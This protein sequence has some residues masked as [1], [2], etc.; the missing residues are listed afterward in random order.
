MK[1]RISLLLFLISLFNSFLLYSQIT[2]TEI[3]KSE[4][5]IVLKPE[6]YDSLNNWQ[7]FERLGDY[8]QYIG[9]KIYLPPFENPVIGSNVKGDAIRDSNEGFANENRLNVTNE[10]GVYSKHCMLSSKRHLCNGIVNSKTGNKYYTILNVVYG[11]K[12]I[13]SL[14]KMNSE[15]RYSIKEFYLKTYEDVKMLFIIK[16]DSTGD[17]IYCNNTQRFILV[18]YFVKQK[19]LFQNNYFI[20]IKDPIYY[21]DYSFLKD[22]IEKFDNRYIEKY[23][24]DNGNEISS[25]KKVIVRLGSK[26]LC[27]E[28]TLFKNTLYWEPYLNKLLP[29]INSFYDIIYILKNDKGEQ[30][31]LSYLDGFI[32]EQ[33]YLKIK[34][35]KKLQSQQLNTKR[36]QEELIKEENKRKAFERNRTECINKFGQQ[37]GE[38]IANSKVKIGM[39]TEMC[40]AAWGIPFW[41]SKTTTE[42]GTNEDWYYGFGYSLH[43]VNSN[44]IRIEE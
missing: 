38:L 2:I 4:E 23:E 1:S 24:D 10:E 37:N 26:W 44:L 29:D 19:Q 32:L 41:T 21:W 9:L 35:N 34:M 11:E 18:P 12:G 17:T 6:S 39:T 22:S 5:R 42:N 8:K 13:D 7:S 31:T 15:L 27:T 3:Q 30:F 28:V 33:D 43:F 36:K 16:N 25:Y 20:Y 40:K 14:Q